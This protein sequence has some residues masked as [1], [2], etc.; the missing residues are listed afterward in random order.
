MD[1][2]IKLLGP[3]YQK[4]FSSIANTPTGNGVSP[5]QNYQNAKN[6]YSD[7]NAKIGQS[8]QDAMQNGVNGVAINPVPAA[9]AMVNGIGQDSALTSGLLRDMINGAVSMTN[10]GITQGV[11]QQG[12]MLNY[13]V[14]KE[15]ANS[16]KTTAQVG[17]GNS[18]WY[19]D[20]NGNVTNNKPGNGSGGTGNP[21]I[22]NYVGS[23]MNGYTSISSIPADIQPRVLA[24]L[25]KKGYDPAKELWGDLNTLQGSYN[26]GGG[27]ATGNNLG[28]QAS[29]GIGDLLN[30]LGIKTGGEQQKQ[31]YVSASQ[32]FA[33]KYGSLLGKNID[34][35]TMK[36]TPEMAAKKFAAL[37]TAIRN[38][39]YQG[40]SAPGS[41]SN[42]K[43]PLGLGL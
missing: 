40:G 12:N 34:L 23:V 4:A 38:K 18:G 43:D 3:A 10:N 19:T 5:L 9:S 26:K 15:N 32:N 11:N 28:A 21:R 37:S 39:F 7:V 17:A 29:M 33:S 35:P 36:D 31:E 25:S 8:Q 27:L 14:N 24:E 30:L 6:Y 1:T 22:D 2:F 42:T 41:S 16:G 13:D 20:A